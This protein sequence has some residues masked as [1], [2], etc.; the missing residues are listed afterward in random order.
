MKEHRLKWERYSKEHVGQDLATG[1][2]KYKHDFYEQE[3]TGEELIDDIKT[4][5]SKFN[6]HHD[7]AKQQDADWGALKR[8][9][10]LGSFVSVQA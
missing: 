9:F 8:N 2:D 1:E 4:T 7:L 6:P 10:P 3:G 5:L